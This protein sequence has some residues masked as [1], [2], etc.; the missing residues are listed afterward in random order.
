LFFFFFLNRWAD[1]G[2]HWAAFCFQKP[3]S[4]V[5]AKRWL[6]SILAAVV[7]SHRALSSL[8]FFNK[9]KMVNWRCN[10]LG[11]MLERQSIERSSYAFIYSYL[12]RLVDFKKGETG[13]THLG[14]AG[15]TCSGT[16]LYFPSL[17]REWGMFLWHTDLS[18]NYLGVVVVG[19][20]PIIFFLGVLV[21]F[22]R[23]T[24]HQFCPHSSSLFFPCITTLSLPMAS[25]GLITFGR[26]FNFRRL[27]YLRKLW[28]ISFFFFFFCLSLTL[29]LV[30]DLSLL[31]HR[32]EEYCDYP[33][34]RPFDKFFCVIH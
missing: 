17:F 15:R 23:F 7:I 26:I 34:E 27:S 6:L 22:V 11:G 19:L 13:T 18:M 10:R 24:S 1:Y 28:L 29:F 32:R 30:N 9:K 16:V 21:D 4:L 12:L 3:Y 14:R 31:L 20:C 2:S 5:F 33:L 25:C 8:N